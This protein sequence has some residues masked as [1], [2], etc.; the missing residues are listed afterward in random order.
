[1]VRD[2]RGAPD[3]LQV[4]SNRFRF[5]G[6]LRIAK[7]AELVDSVS[8]P[9]APELLDRQVHLR[10]IVTGRIRPATHISR[11]SHTL[12]RSIDIRGRFLEVHVN[13]SEEVV[14][15]RGRQ[16]DSDPVSRF[17]RCSRVSSTAA[18]LFKAVSGCLVFSAGAVSFFFFFSPLGLDAFPAAAPPP[19]GPESLCTCCQTGTYATW[20]KRRMAGKNIA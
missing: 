8:K 10:R 1:M 4:I 19:S 5:I 9:A 3:L 6:D 13:E 15:W 12:Q 2:A 18:G 17:A 11:L 14:R 7:F 16:K 20:A